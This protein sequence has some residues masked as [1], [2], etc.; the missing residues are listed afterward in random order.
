MKEIWKDIENYEGYYQ[1][2][3]LGRVRSLDRIVK[4]SDGRI[5]N[6]K[7]KLMSTR[8]SNSNKAKNKNASD[9]ENITLNKDGQIK[10]HLIHRLVA[11][12][13]IPNPENKKTVNHIDGD[14]LNNIVTNLE[15][16]THSENVIHAYNN[17]LYPNITRRMA[18]VNKNTGELI[19]SNTLTEMAKILNVSTAAVRVCA[20]EN[21]KKNK[22]H[23]TC[24]DYYLYYTEPST[25][26]DSA[27]ELAPSAA[28]EF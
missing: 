25:R 26:V 9:R 2:S 4:R 13:F 10:H 11:Q 6:R 28:N 21:M 7:G 8:V 12:A 23:H 17:N 24:K 19:E 22:L 3:N 20:R 27:N 16:A 1:I 15:W 18:G 14:S 5:E